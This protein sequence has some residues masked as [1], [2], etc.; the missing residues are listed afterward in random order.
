MSTKT[1]QL[2][3]KKSSK[4]L[5]NLAKIIFADARFAFARIAADGARRL[6]FPSWEGGSWHHRNDGRDGTP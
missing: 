6:T 2:I 5:R 1:A 4:N 3:L